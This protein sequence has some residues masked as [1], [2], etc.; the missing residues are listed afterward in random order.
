MWKIHVKKYTPAAFLSNHK[1]LNVHRALT[2]MLNQSQESATTLSVLES[3]VCSGLLLACYIV[4]FLIGW[5][6]SKLFSLMWSWK[7]RRALFHMPDCIDSQP[8]WR[9]VGE[10]K[11]YWILEGQQI[12]SKATLFYIP[13]DIWQ[14]SLCLRNRLHWLLRLMARCRG[15]GGTGCS[16]HTVTKAATQRP[17]QLE[18]G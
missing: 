17:S 4:C 7:P 13:V 5:L 11:M 16:D 8:S 14:L 1:M 2:G 18:C 3:G 6:R 12:I 9:M 10:L 15:R